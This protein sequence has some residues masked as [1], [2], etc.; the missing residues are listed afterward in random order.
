MSEELS[1]LND[2]V[3]E[4]TDLSSAQ[5]TKD[6]KLIRTRWVVCNK[7]DSESPDIRARLVACEIND[8]K[9]DSYFASTPPLEAKRLL[10]S[11]FSSKRRVPNGDALE[12]SFVDV[13]KA[14]FNAVPVRNVHVQFPKEFGAP[15]GKVAHLKRCVYGC[16]DA[17]LLWEETYAHC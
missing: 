15:K 1:Y 3:W 12:L 5:T 10:F 6:F 4:A 13:K 14:Y 9:N 7:G 2:V 11:Q 16:R 17:G 8:Q